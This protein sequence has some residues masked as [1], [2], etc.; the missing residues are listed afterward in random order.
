M[1]RGQHGLFGRKVSF[2]PVRDA[3]PSGDDVRVGRAR[4]R[5][6]LDTERVEETVPVRREEA[7]VDQ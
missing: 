2:V 4:L 1:A 3:E 5:K 6:W 7:R